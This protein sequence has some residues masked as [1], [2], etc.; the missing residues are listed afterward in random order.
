MELV[1]LLRLAQNETL[2]KERL[3]REHIFRLSVSRQI[4]RYQ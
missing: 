2:K 3:G 1:V 4:D